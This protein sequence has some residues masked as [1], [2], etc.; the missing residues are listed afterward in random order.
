[1]KKLKEKDIY[2]QEEDYE[3]YLRSIEK[4]KKILE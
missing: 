3:I 2:L 1:M 4:L